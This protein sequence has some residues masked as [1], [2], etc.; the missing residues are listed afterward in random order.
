ME[1]KYPNDTYPRETARWIPHYPDSTWKA[2][3]VTD[4]YICSGC[5]KKVGSTDRTTRCP[6]CDRKMSH[7]VVI[8]YD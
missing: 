4:Y 3:G 1:T 8:L 2:A 5:W 6:H 7:K